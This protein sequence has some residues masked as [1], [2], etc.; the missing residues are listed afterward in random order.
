ME[1]LGTSF[2]RCEIK[3]TE[4]LPAKFLKVL[5]HSN[6]IEKEGRREREREREEKM[7]RRDQ[8]RAKMGGGDQNKRKPL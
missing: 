4:D 5:R 8:I 3:S 2:C 6:G 1:V 7:S